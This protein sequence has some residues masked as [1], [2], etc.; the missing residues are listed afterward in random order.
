MCSDHD[1]TM[2]AVAEQFDLS[3]SEEILQGME[4]RPLDLQPDPEAASDL[5]RRFFRTYPHEELRDLFAQTSVSELKHR[6][7]QSLQQESDTAPE[8]PAEM[9]PDTVPVPYLPSFIRGDEQEPVDYA[10]GARRGTAFHR[11]LELLDYA[12]REEWIEDALHGGSKAAAWL[13]ALPDTGKIQK[14]DADLVSMRAF[15]D[16][17]RSPL[18][19]RMAFAQEAGKLFREQP[20]VM[21]CPADEVGEGLPHDETVTVQGIIDAFFIEDGGIILVDYKTDRVRE[22]GELRA[23]YRTQINLYAQA[24]QNAFG[25]PVTQRLIYSSSL[26][27]EIEI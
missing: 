20:F 4:R 10:S 12:Y 11:V 6:A 8:I 27:E 15:M 9:F 22:A 24:L 5:A 13:R 14:E 19:E 17:L 16:F 18:A 2:H 3:R 1:L 21:G 25:M 7:M 23:R 26:G